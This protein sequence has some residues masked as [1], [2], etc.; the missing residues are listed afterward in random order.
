M[1]HGTYTGLALAY[2]IMEV[3]LPGLSRRTTL[4]KNKVGLLA[5]VE[6]GTNTKFRVDHKLHWQA[7]KSTTRLQVLFPPSLNAKPI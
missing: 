5:Q 7:C 3:P 2:I 1:V 4:A 6:L